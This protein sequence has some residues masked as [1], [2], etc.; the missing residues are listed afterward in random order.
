MRKFC[1]AICLLL[2]LNPLSAQSSRYAITLEAAPTFSYMKYKYSAFSIVDKPIGRYYG[3]MTLYYA[4]GERYG[5]VSGVGFER[6]G[7][8]SQIDI[9]NENGDFLGKGDY[10]IQLDYV[11]VPLLFRKV[12]GAKNAF[13]VDMGGSW[14]CLI[15]QEASQRFQNIT[16]YSMNTGL[17]INDFSALVGVGMRFPLWKNWSLPITLRSQHSLFTLA[18]APN[19]RNFNIRNNTAQLAI[20]LTYQYH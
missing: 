1:L 5:I 8:K 2:A 18:P 12:L 11:S 3:G 4:L 13:F 6:K 19:P 16:H 7:G 15:K 17:I 10:M 20:G 9:I 14:G